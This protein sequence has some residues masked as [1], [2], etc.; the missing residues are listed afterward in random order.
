M[1]LL[2]KGSEMRKI[3]GTDVN[4]RSSRSHLILTLYLEVRQN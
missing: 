4:E 3:R 2:S 1:K